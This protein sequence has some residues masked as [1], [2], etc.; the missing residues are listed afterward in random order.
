[1][2]LLGPDAKGLSAT[3]VTRLKGIWQEEYQTWS[4]RSLEGKRY[5]YVWAD[6]VS[7]NIS[8]LYKSIATT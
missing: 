4:Q 3:T 1:M 6:P 8:A 7:T 2:A 5:V